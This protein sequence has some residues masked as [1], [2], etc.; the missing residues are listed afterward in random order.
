MADKELKKIATAKGMEKLFSALK[1]Q[2]LFPG[3][4]NYQ[5]WCETKEILK[6]KVEVRK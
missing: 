2:G 6:D 5:D 1:E 3:Y 4:K